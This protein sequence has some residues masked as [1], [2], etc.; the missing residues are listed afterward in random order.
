MQIGFAVTNQAF[1]SEPPENQAT[2]DLDLDRLALYLRTS[3]VP[4]EG[5]LTSVLITG[6]RSNPTYA[7]SDSAGT[8]WILRRPPHGL[9]LE[10]AHDMGREF[11]VLSALVPTTVPVPTPLKLCKD[12]S[13]IGAPFYVMDRLNGRT[14][15][16]RDDAKALSPSQRAGLANTMIRTLVD[17]HQVDPATAGLGDWGRPEGYLERQL[18]RWRKQ[19]DAVKRRELPLF[20]E[21][22]SILTTNLPETFRP[23]IV[24]GDFKIDNLMVSNEDPTVAV[25]L[26]D[27]EMSTL[28]DTM[29]DLGLLISFWDEPGRPF[30]PLTNGTTAMQGFPSAAEMVHKYASALS[31]DPQSVD[32]YVSLADLKIAVIFEQIHVRHAAGMTVGSGFEGIGDMVQPLLERAR[33]RVAGAAG[34]TR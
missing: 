8:D 5:D 31:I 32:W 22:H 25:G 6:G 7:L 24:H 11:K 9:V 34:P 3:G 14:I 13:I 4:V 30:N 17:L 2:T 26:L 19:W 33:E 27:W 12:P 10:S 29:A 16:S 1:R 28:G 21:A 18:G 15:E 23:G 20:N